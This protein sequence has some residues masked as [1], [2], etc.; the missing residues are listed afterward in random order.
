MKPVKLILIF[1]ALGFIGHPALGQKSDHKDRI[2]SKIEY[3]EKHD[4]L[5]IK[6]LKESETYYDKAGNVIEEIE[7]KKGKIDEHFKYQYDEDNNKIREEEYDPSGH[8]IEYS[9]WKYENGLKVKKIVY[10]RKGN[11]KSRKIWEY[12]KY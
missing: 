9:E 10:D 11:V 3:K 4:A 8:L 1:C 12:T 6:R 7:Y 2:K 5:I